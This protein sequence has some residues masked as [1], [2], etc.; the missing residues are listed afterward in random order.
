[1]HIQMGSYELLL[2]GIL[3]FLRLFQFSSVQLLSR[4]QIYVTPWTTARQDLPGMSKL[5]QLPEFNQ[6]HV[7]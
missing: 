2:G 3:K 4:V 6:T 1:M 7:H 5:C